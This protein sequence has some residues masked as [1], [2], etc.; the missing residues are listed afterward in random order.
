MFFASSQLRLDKSAEIED[1]I[2]ASKSVN[3]AILRSEMEKSDHFEEVGVIKTYFDTI[4]SGC[5]LY[6]SPSPRDS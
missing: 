4:Y 6:T 3:N 1:Q 5:L 2:Q